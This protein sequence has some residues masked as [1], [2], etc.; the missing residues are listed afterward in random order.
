[1]ITKQDLKKFKKDGYIK[2]KCVDKRKLLNLRNDFV[3]M[4][5]VNFRKTFPEKKINITNQT[6]RIN[7]LLNDALI[8]LEKKNHKNLSDLFD[9]IARCTSF[10]QVIS[11]KKITSVVNALLNRDKNKN[12]YIN[13]NTIRMDIPGL[14]KFVY[15]WHQDHTSNIANS[16]FIQMWLPPFGD[17]NKN[18]GPL[19][20]LKDSFKYTINTTHS[21]VE[22]LHHKK[23]I[24]LNMQKVNHLRASFNTKLLERKNQF[25]EKLLTCKWGEVI[26]F[27]KQ[28]MHKTGVNKTK[29]KMRYILGCFYHDI[30]SPYWRFMSYDHKSKGFQEKKI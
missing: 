11:D 8:L 10:Y 29:N 6:K 12:L 2:L 30:L 27:N 18:L 28:L 1:M 15:G 9:Q 16:N 25:K 4:V 23:Y 19:H 3:N 13:C 26:F 17:N 21:N 24:P 14:T 5:E 20:V 22:N 7:F